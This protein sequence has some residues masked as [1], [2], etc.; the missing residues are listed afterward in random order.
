MFLYTCDSLIFIY[1]KN[2]DRYSRN[3]ILAKLPNDVKC[4]YAPKNAF[5]DELMSKA[6]KMLGTNGKIISKMF[7]KRNCYKKRN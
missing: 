3:D 1:I 2:L 6:A 5:I 7:K 4:W